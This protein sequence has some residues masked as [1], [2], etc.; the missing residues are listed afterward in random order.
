MKVP[1]HK[2]VLK[3]LLLA[4]LLFVFRQSQAQSSPF[5]TYDSLT[6]ALYNAGDWKNLIKTGDSAIEAG[7]DYFF[8][9]MRTGIAYFQLKKYR[10]ATKYFRKALTYSTADQGASQYLYYSYLMGGCPEMAEAMNYASALNA[11]DTVMKVRFKSVYAETGF[12]AGAVS[13]ATP[14][15][16]MGDSM[17]YGEREVYQDVFYY[18]AG[19][20]IKFAPRTS[21]YVSGSLLR[22]NRQKQFAFNLYNETTNNLATYD[23]TFNYDYAQKDLYAAANFLSANG[24]LIMPAFH[25]SGGKPVNIAS[26][27]SGTDYSFVQTPFTYS[28]YAFSVMMLKN[29]GNIALGLQASVAKLSSEGNQLQSSV[30][31]TWFPLGNLNLYATATLTAL[32]YGGSNYLIADGSFGLKLLPRLW[33]EGLVTRGNMQYSTEK[34]AFIIYNMAEKIVM[35]SGANLI[36]PINSHLEISLMYRYF[37]REYDNWY[38]NGISDTKLTASATRYNNQSF[39]G[40]VKWNF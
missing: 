25:Y 30:S 14:G 24:I 36:I 21:V 15:Q 18:H 31:A 5:R 39:Y 27:Y 1:L 34:N 13:E 28:H 11:T 33:L 26:L 12:T 9:Q 23:T 7:H 29:T 22:I 4:G 16:I 10:K 6:F 17:V 8:M 32:R 20:K 40:G 35:R 2:I 3:S 37:I 19:T 38:L